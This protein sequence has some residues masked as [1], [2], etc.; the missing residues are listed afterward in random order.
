MKSSRSYCFAD[1]NGYGMRCFIAMFLITAWVARATAQVDDF[2]DIRFWVGTGS[3]R[4]A[5]VI[6]WAGT[7]DLST[8]VWGYRWNGEAHGETMLRAVVESD[9]RL[10]A[11]LGEPG[12][13][14]T[15]LFGIGYDRDRD[16]FGLSD[17]TPFNSVGIAV[18]SPSDDATAADPSDSY[19]E[20]WFSAGFWGYYG[21]NGNPYAGGVWEESFVGFSDRILADGDWDGFRYA[22]EFQFASPSQGFPALAPRSFVSPLLETPATGPSVVPEPWSSTYLAFGVLFCLLQIRQRF[23]A[24]SSPVAGPT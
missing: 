11:R 7:P 3:N 23:L 9:P 17:G 8:L 24:S 14:G 19:N 5:L 12:L 2:A 4:A 1:L 10:F 13:F 18:T 15:P 21:G 22:P 16:G 20:G 6:D